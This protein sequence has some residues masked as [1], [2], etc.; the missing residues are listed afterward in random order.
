MK[1]IS[2]EKYYK[3]H[4][5]LPMDSVEC[6]DNEI[7]LCSKLGELFNRL[8]QTNPELERLKEFWWV[9]LHSLPVKDLYT[10]TD[11][12]YLEKCVD[13]MLAFINIEG[14][15]IEH[16]GTE[17]ADKFATLEIYVVIEETTKEVLQKDQ[18]LRVRAS[19]KV[20]NAQGVRKWGI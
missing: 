14:V 17:Y 7:N 6:G 11:I 5:K 13:G 9:A 10:E 20:F 12:E 8:A 1:D 2:C 16:L 3:L 19:K 18:V 15:S 4:H